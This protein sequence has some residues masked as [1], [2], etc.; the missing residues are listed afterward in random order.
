MHALIIED[1]AMIAMCIEEALRDCGFATFDFADCLETAVRAAEEA[2]P[3]LI[4]ADVRLTH[5]CGIEAVQVICAEKPIPVIFL[6]SSWRDV[7]ARLPG[8]AL[9]RKPFTVAQLS[10]AVRALPRQVQGDAAQPAVD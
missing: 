3:D 7:E 9:L 4:T 8:Y 2:C 10:K 5:S 6:T 1:E